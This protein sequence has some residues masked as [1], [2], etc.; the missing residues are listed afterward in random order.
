[1]QAHSPYA[2]GYVEAGPKKYN[3]SPAHSASQVVLVAI[4]SL[5]KHLTL[6]QGEKLHC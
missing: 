4:T 2:R 3:K 5:L 1:M 6:L